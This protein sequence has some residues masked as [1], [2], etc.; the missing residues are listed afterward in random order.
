VD[1]AEFEHRLQS[2]RPPRY[3]RHSQR[4]NLNSREFYDCIIEIV[5]RLVA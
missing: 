5:R 4:L 3:P 1:L 2:G